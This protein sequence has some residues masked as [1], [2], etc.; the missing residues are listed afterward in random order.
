M[1]L[2]LTVQE[3]NIFTSFRFLFRETEAHKGSE[4]A[5][6]FFPVSRVLFSFPERKNVFDL[7]DGNTES[8]NLPMQGEV[9]DLLAFATVSFSFPLQGHAFDLLDVDLLLPF[10]FPTPN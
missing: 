3:Y 6:D 4:D 9:F 1:N 7:L 2:C 5:L 8:F 10:S